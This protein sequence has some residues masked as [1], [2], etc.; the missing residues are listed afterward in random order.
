MLRVRLLAVPLLLL[1]AGCSGGAAAVQ[2]GWDTG[3]PDGR[4][5]LSGHLT[6]VEQ[7]LTGHP[8][9]T[10]PAIDSQYWYGDCP[11]DPDNQG[12]PV[13]EDENPQ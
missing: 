5:A 6:M 8:G 7:W 11:V 4:A 13:E 9:Q 1:L 3:S 2:C 10:P 12:P